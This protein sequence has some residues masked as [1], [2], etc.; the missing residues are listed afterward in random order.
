[1]KKMVTA[2]LV[3]VSII[4]AISVSSVLRNAS[5]KLVEEPE[6]SETGS[7]AQD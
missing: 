4:A 5:D 6:T 7:S 1:M 3:L 2:I